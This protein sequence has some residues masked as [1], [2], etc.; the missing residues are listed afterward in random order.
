MTRW[1]RGAAGHMLRVLKEQIAAGNTDLSLLDLAVLSGYSLPTV[2][3][4]VRQLEADSYISRQ[5][6]GPHRCTRYALI[7]EDRRRVIIAGQAIGLLATPG[8]THAGI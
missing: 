2:H 3:A 1:P 6:A 7:S 5:F 4:A 8:G